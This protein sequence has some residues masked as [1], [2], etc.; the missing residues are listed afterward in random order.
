MDER[1]HW[2]LTLSA[3]GLWALTV[4]AVYFFI[5]RKQLKGLEDLSP[6][7]RSKLLKTRHQRDLKS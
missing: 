6:R 5:V 4:W 3:L 1:L 2:A 7:E